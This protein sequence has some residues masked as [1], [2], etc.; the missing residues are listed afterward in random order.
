MPAYRSPPPDVEFLK[1]PFNRIPVR[2]LPSAR[3][4]PPFRM[5]PTMMTMPHRP[6]PSV[7]TSPRC[8]SC[9]GPGGVALSAGSCAATDKALMAFIAFIAALA[10][11][12]ARR[13]TSLFRSIVRFLSSSSSYYPNAEM[14]KDA[15]QQRLAEGVG[16]ESVDRWAGVSWPCCQLE[17]TRS[18]SDE[19]L[20]FQQA[21]VYTHGG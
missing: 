19:Q 13:R 17:P 10:G 12:D 5:H 11:A 14:R 3:L 2:S 4:F 9:S 15:V 8:Y 18:I 16:N 6:F 7:P 1:Q 20:R 21:R